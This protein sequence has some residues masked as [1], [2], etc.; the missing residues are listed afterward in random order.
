MYLA[1]YVVVGGAQQFV[2]KKLSYTRLWYIIRP[3]LFT[4]I[5]DIHSGH[6]YN[7]HTSVCIYVLEVL[8]EQKN[9]CRVS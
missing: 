9:D 3:I 2:S 8:Y 5:L 7:I 4:F 6:Y 1:W